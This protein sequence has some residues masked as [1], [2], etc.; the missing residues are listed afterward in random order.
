MGLR[1]VERALVAMQYPQQQYHLRQYGGSD[2]GGYGS[3]ALVS[4]VGTTVAAVVTGKKQ[5][6]VAED[7]SR[8]QLMMLERSSTS[9]ALLAQ[10]SLA[11]NLQL[12]KFII[13]LFL[14]GGLAAIVIVRDKKK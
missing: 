12:A 1:S 3:A 10:H 2:D 5:A 6:E 4:L 11:S 14:I 7:A 9:D 13:P 8:A